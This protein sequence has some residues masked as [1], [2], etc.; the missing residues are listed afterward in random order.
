M[1]END[2]DNIRVKIFIVI[3]FIFLI[4]FEYVNFSKM[5]NLKIK[6]CNHCKKMSKYFNLIS[7][8]LKY[9]ILSL[10]IIAIK[11]SLNNCLFKNVVYLPL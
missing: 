3:L 2:A 6:L 10:H 7:L 8:S 4:N 11:N 9:I 5:N 1:S